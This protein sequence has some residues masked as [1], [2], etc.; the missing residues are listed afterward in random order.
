MRI[1]IDLQSSA[2]EWPTSLMLAR[3]VARYR[4]D[5]E[6]FVLL[7][8]AE[9]ERIFEMRKAF[10]DILP[11]DAQRVWS[12]PEDL[13]SWKPSVVEAGL[14]A[15]EHL[16][17][18]VLAT[19]EPDALLL[20]GLSDG[21]REDCAANVDFAADLPT[22]ILRKPFPS[23]SQAVSLMTPE[24]LQSFAYLRRPLEIFSIG[25]IPN[26]TASKLAATVPS[27]LT[28][29]PALSLVPQNG[30]A[31]E[32]EVAA[33]RIISRLEEVVS[34]S[35]EEPASN[36]TKRPR[37]A[38][39]SPFPPVKSGISEYSAQ[40]LPMLAQY[41]EIEVIVDQEQV[42]DPL[43]DGRFPAHSAE[44]L[45]RNIAAFDRVLYHFG[46]SPAHKYMYD[47]LRK[48]P[49]IVV[50][51]DFYLK[52]WQIGGRL[53]KSSDIVIRNHGV[54]ALIEGL[55]LDPENAS[56]WS[57]PAN[58]EVLQNATSVIVHSQESCRLG[59]KWY[60]EGTTDDWRVIPLLRPAV[61]VTAHDR[62]KART[63]LGFEED[64][65]VICSFGH[66][67][68][69]KLGVTLLSAFKEAR[70]SAGERAKLIFVGELEES[71]AAEFNNA[72]TTETGKVSQVTGWIDTDRYRDY[73]LAA[74]IAVQ[75]RSMSRG[76]TSASVLD[77]LTHGT[78]TI[79]NA[80]G[81]MLE[82][83]PET[84]IVI[85]DPVLED[86][87]TRTL[88]KLANDA[89]LRM[90]IGTK[91]RDKIGRLH[92]PHRCAA[93]YHQA[94]EASARSTQRAVDQLPNR[95]AGLSL[96]ETDQ[97]AVAN[98]MA[99][100]FP[101]SPRQKSLFVDIS[102]VAEHDIHTGIQRVTRAILNV[103]LLDQDTSY[104][105]VPVRLRQDGTFS[106]AYFYAEKLLGLPFGKVSEHIIDVARGDC[107][108]GLDLEFGRNEL[109][110]KV[111]QG[112]QDAGVT[113]WHV[114]Y[115]LLP[116]RLPQYFPSH[117][118]GRFEDW[119]TM[120]TAF[121]GAACISRTTAED[122][123]AWMS[124]KK[125]ERAKPFEITWFHLG[126]DI[127]SSI[128]T[129]GLPDDAEE[130]LAR[131]TQ[132]PTFL[133]VGTVEP[134]KGHAQ[135]VAAFDLLWADGIDVDLI[136]VGKK[137][138]E[139]SQF[140]KRLLQHPENGKRLF[141]FDSISDEYLEKLYAASSCLIAASEGEGFGLP[142]IEAGQ[143]RLP[144]MARGLRVF[145]EIAGENAVY[146]DGMEP[147]SLAHALRD[148]LSAWR[149][150][151]V[152]SS[153][154]IAWLTWKQSAEQLR[155]AI[156]ASGTQTQSGGNDHRGDTLPS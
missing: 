148:W 10:H 100:N 40:L 79:V 76:E 14:K 132:K 83:N 85:S 62:A 19:L 142:L 43:I 18:A 123:Q 47:L 93:L 56:T 125:V 82:L 115:D 54:R 122:L 64:D 70:L 78:A 97:F 153:A 120:V 149:K 52:D 146:F 1:V 105:I 130:F 129:R 65:L 108:L 46:N 131:L 111:F 3:A 22:A 92:A 51:H 99:R 72:N 141:W 96:T 75:L 23:A 135:T 117:S 137:G 17:M 81:S 12:A 15:N 38:F 44:W 124:E 109:R 57:L 133:M 20:T 101:P 58:L 60:G 139:M 53:R 5:H 30:A 136:I 8:A 144:I 25:P 11:A 107:F 152:V 26:D 121:D 143:H 16:R 145:R 7:N 33:K 32:W 80:H 27:H 74:D 114:V 42:S 126:A 119:L 34:R 9:R 66:V 113:V 118:A 50:L 48:I 55:H 31:S 106:T 41:Y 77:C 151:N 21:Y 88:E 112:F 49:G 45:E 6:V 86:E 90:E 69:T 24:Q 116:V 110:R 61:D 4:G 91:A 134:R 102:A 84:V 103:L 128:P 71:Y 127:E 39:V 37:L 73:L 150:G 67:T 13:M 98:A 36:T 63:R 87:L 2:N 154:S 138:W 140:I 29:L 28:E 156:G 68:R 89:N 59:T 35:A 147:D 155:R 104:Q 94:I 95:I